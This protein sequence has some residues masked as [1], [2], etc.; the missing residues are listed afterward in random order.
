MGRAVVNKTL[1][2]KI[3]QQHKMYTIEYFKTKN[4]EWFFHIV[5]NGRIVL[6]SGESY[7]SKSNCL[8]A[9]KRLRVLNLDMCRIVERG[10]L[11]NKIKLDEE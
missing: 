11:L 8:R 10:I 9:I 1:R 7:S 2:N 5:I 6:D 4:D 3:A